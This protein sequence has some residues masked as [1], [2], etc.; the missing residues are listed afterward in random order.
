MTE[1]IADTGTTLSHTYTG[2]HS[3]TLTHTLRGVYPHTLDPHWQRVVAGFL[4]W[5]RVAQTNISLGRRSQTA[6]SLI[7]KKKV[8]G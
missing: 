5:A 7:M 1:L 4:A 2:I 6:T 3:Y 8:A